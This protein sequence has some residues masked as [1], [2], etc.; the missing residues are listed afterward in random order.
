M[1][2][3][4]LD[5]R[6]DRP[7]RRPRLSRGPE[8]E[9]KAATQSWERRGQPAGAAQTPRGRK[10][11]GRERPVRPEPSGQ[12][13]N[14]RQQNG[15]GDKSQHTGPQGLRAGGCPTIDS[16]KVGRETRGD[17]LRHGQDLGTERGG[18]SSSHNQR[19]LLMG[20]MRGRTE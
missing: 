20:G 19:P 11:V 13:G 14:G 8:E 9:T 3:A 15:K 18:P 6:T 16:L 1:G 17:G 10:G 12:K 7:L 2:E 5:G 4:T